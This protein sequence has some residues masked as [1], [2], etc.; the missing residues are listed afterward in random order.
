MKQYIMGML[1]GASLILCAVMFMGQTS[2]DGTAEGY[3]KVS[4]W[5][6]DRYREAQKRDAKAMGQSNRSILDGMDD[7]IYN[8][9]YDLKSL[10]ATVNKIAKA[11]DNIG[12]DIDNI[13]YYGV[14]CK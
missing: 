4:K 2:R 6:D 8:M 5:L 14:N 7:G 11:V 12:S 13:S 9:N 10:T 1:T 3:D